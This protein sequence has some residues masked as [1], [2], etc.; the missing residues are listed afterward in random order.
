[1]QTTLEAD[2]HSYKEKKE[3]EISVLEGAGGFSPTFGIIGTV[4]GL[5]QVLSNISDANSLA[6][7]ISSAFIA[8]LYGIVFANVIYLPSAN[9]LKV[10]LKRQ[11]VYREMIID[12][13]C[14][15]ASGES[16]RNIENK[17]SLYYHAF[18]GG[19]KKY[20]AGIEN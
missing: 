20:K 15:L 6:K 2:I 3:M 18:E 11:L 12:G 13:M 8:T 14:M 16:S 10:C 4:M 1:M 9:H 19:E 7:S 17:L 5:V